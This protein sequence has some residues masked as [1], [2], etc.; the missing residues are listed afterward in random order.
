MLSPNMSGIP[1]LVEKQTCIQSQ[2]LDAELQSILCIP[3]A[4][5][6]IR[7]IVGNAKDLLAAWKIFEEMHARQRQVPINRRYVIGLAMVE[8]AQKHHFYFYCMAC[9]EEGHDN[10]M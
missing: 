2:Q 4:R 8:R 9:S 10:F 5:G 6:G 7:G 3:I 1:T